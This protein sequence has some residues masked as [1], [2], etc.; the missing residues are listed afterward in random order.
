MDQLQHLRRLVIA[1]EVLARGVPGVG[2]RR[3][4][5]RVA[6]RVA[7]PRVVRVEPL[8]QREV[9]AVAQLRRVLAGRREQL[10]DDVPPRAELDRVAVADLGVP[11]REAVVVLGRQDVVLGARVR[12]QLQPGARVEL[13]RREHRDEVVVDEV[14]A[15]LLGVV[16]VGR[17]VGVL[18]V[19]PVPLRVLLP[20][21]RPRGYGVDAPVDEDAELAVVEP[22]RRAVRR[23]RR[24][25]R[26]EVRDAEGDRHLLG[27]ERAAPGRH[28]ELAVRGGAGRD[29]RV[30]RQAEPHGRLLP[31]CER[32]D[33]RRD[34]GAA[35]GDVEG[36]RDAVAGAEPDG[37]RRSPRL[38]RRPAAR[39][40]SAGSPSSGRPAPART[41]RRRRAAG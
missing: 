24:V 34:R 31:R 5:V 4:G 32:A 18:L 12:D 3:A 36:H 13:L 41:G 23:E 22:V 40:R 11:Q 16:C 14:L 6:R 33:G 17:A 9:Q 2:H 38:P 27:G 20:D 10:G 39:R 35:A 21:R 19:L 1:D 28:A 25:G 30:R 7:H 26:P 37:R 15:V 8:R 29:G